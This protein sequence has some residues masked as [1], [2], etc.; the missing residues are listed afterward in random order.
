M[1]CCPVGEEERGEFCEVPEEVAGAVT[2]EG[3]HQGEEGDCQGRPGEEGGE[4]GVE[5]RASLDG[6]QEGER[7]EE[8][9]REDG[10]EGTE[11][12]EG[13]EEL[14]EGAGDD[15]QVAKSG[16]EGGEEQQDEEEGG[17]QPANPQVKEGGVKKGEAGL[18]G[19]GGGGGG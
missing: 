16:G 5:G 3:G 6:H 11:R 12:S 8:A 4:V 9:E 1:D 2:Q 13:R 17:P 15:F 18:E 14:E 19:K 7:G 10:E